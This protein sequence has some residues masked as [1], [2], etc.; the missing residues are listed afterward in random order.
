MCEIMYSTFPVHC[1]RGPVACC[2]PTLAICL[3]DHSDAARLASISSQSGK[4]APEFARRS[5][6]VHA[7]A[8]LEEHER[9]CEAQRATQT[10]GEHALDDVQSLA[11]V[12]EIH[13]L[14]ADNEDPINSLALA[15][16]A[17]A[18]IRAGGDAFETTSTAATRQT[19][20]ATEPAPAQATEATSHASERARP[21]LLPVMD[22][23][24]TSPD[25]P[26]PD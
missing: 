22:L 5:N 9:L 12:T 8:L 17:D 21:T 4:T 15:A 6:R 1:P 2:A 20:G 11:Q 19:M 25:S 7:V 13:H 24:L 14:D 10:A 18:S 23:S 16:S 26:L 3:L